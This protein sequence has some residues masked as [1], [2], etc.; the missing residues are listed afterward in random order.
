MI[1]GLGLAIYGIT[2]L[3]DS[4][5]SLEI[6]GLELSAEDAGKRNESYLMI[7]LGVLCLIGGFFMNRKK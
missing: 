1:A 4:S 7:G 2:Q 6:G 5:A 3:G